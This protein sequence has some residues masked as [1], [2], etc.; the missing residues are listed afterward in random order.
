MKMDN[1]ILI[2]RVLL[3]T[4]EQKMMNQEH[5]FLSLLYRHR[6]RHQKTVTLLILIPVPA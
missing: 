4:L 6:H 2:N 1:A 3:D 5:V